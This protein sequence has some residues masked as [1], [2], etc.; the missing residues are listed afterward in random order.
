[1]RAIA[2]L[3]PSPSRCHRPTRARVR[4]CVCV[5]VFLFLCVC[6]CLVLRAWVFVI[7]RVFARMC[8]RFSTSA[9]R[10]LGAFSLALSVM[11]EFA[12]CPRVNSLTAPRILLLRLNRKDPRRRI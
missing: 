8:A 2:V 6:V 1:M 3:L 9:R 10:A 11:E 4:A 12:A 7:T 5:C